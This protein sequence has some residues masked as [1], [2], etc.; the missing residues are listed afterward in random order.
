MNLIEAVSSDL[1]YRRK[2]EE[3]WLGCGD[4]VVV[5]TDDILANDW[6]T[7]TYITGSD[8]AERVNSILFDK[9]DD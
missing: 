3:K 4:G 5:T 1:P 8:L 6:E 9:K 7:K 2:G